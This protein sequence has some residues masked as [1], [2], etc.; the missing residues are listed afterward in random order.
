[1]A[2]T[3]LEKAGNGAPCQPL[4]SNLN[5][6]NMLSYLPLVGPITTVYQEMS[7][8]KEYRSLLTN[9]PEMPIETRKSLA[10]NLIQSKNECK[11]RSLVRNI[12][13]IALI[14][15]G[16]AAGIFSL[17]TGLVCV[18]IH[19]GV[20]WENNIRIQKNLEALDMLNTNLFPQ[21]IY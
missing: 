5:Y 7:L 14:V 20:I 19:L 2:T 18:G 13:S 17:G 6:L 8:V 4:E 9:S 16:V 15:A 12:V 11:Q 10:V 1:M 3:T 21:T